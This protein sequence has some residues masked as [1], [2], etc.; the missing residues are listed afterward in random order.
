MIKQV[1]NAITSRK[2]YAILLSNKIVVRFF[3]SIGFIFTIIFFLLLLRPEWGNLF[4]GP[5]TPGSIPIAVLGDSDSH[6]YRDDYLGIRRGG[7]YH[8]LTFQ[9]T[10]ILQLLRSSE[11]DLGKYGY[12]GTRGF[13]Y[14]IRSRL[15]LKARM[16]RKQDYEYNFAFSGATC[17]RLSPDSYQKQ[18]L[19]VSNLVKQN[20]EYWENGLIIIRIGINDIGKLSDFKKYIS[21]SPSSVAPINNCITHIEE[22][23]SLIRQ[24]HKSVK[25]VLVGI[26]DNSNW[27]LFEKVSTEE[28]ILINHYMDIYDNGLRRLA[29]NDD[30][31]LFVDDRMWYAETLGFWDGVRYLGKRKISLNGSTSIYNS[32]GNHPSNIALAD[33]HAG[34]VANALWLRNLQ[35]QINRAF[36]MNLSI[37]QEE[38]IAEL[39]DL[40]GNTGINS[41]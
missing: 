39:V 22:A 18:S 16:P 11:V 28:H 5:Y 15:G 29:E 38:E 20:P 41:N 27:P 37:L 25:I 14:K 26:M 31:I 1:C 36:G 2:T 9:W 13:F 32:K 4:V 19:F 12:W 10:E 8:D 7:K 3:L 30:N 35:S 6:S 17:E 34:T 23:V 21:R 40:K 24:N 33:N